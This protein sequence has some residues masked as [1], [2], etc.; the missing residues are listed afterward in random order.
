MAKKEET[1]KSAKESLNK[2]KGTLTAFKEFISKG[3]VVDMAVGV[4]IGAAF[5]KIVTSLVE[6]IIMPLVGIV[7]GGIDFSGLSLKI[8]ATEGNQAILAYGNFIQSIVDFLIVAFCIFMVV[9]LFDKLKTSVKKEEDKAAEEEPPAKSEE[10]KLLEDI[11]DL[12]KKQK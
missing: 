8:G 3:N 7:A 10:V 4:V 2:A 6:D 11:R 1:K 9:R 12:L 5:G